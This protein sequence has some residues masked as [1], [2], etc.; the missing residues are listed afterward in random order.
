MNINQI[1]AIVSTKIDRL[2]NDIALSDLMNLQHKDLD[3]IRAR[4]SAIVSKT[5]NKTSNQGQ[6]AS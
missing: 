6:G 4:A 2:K 3:E 5:S 1:Y